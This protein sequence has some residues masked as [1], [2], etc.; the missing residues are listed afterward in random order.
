MDTVNPDYGGHPKR[1]L[2][3][4][5]KAVPGC[6]RCSGDAEQEESRRTRV[7]SPLPVF[8]SLYGL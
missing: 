6:G 7:A 2:T 8:G 4:V 1:Y 3:S 5:E